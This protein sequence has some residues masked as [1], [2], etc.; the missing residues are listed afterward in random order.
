MKVTQEQVNLLTDA[1]DDH[2]WIHSDPQRAVRG[3]FNGTIAHGYL[4]LSLAP[5]ISRRCA[6][7]CGDIGAESASTGCGCRRRCLLANGDR[8]GYSVQAVSATCLRST[9]MSA[10]AVAPPH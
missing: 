7:P 5:V 2:Q 1:T 9:A 10:H 4:A 3:S 6:D 8:V